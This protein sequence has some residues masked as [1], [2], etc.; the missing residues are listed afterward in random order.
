MKWFQRSIGFF[1]CLFMLSPLLGFLPK[2]LGEINA[3]TLTEITSDEESATIL[4]LEK[5]PIVIVYGH[6]FKVH[7]KGVPGNIND[8]IRLHRLGA[9]DSEFL[10]AKQ[11]QGQTS[12]T[13]EFNIPEEPGGYELRCWEKDSERLLAVSEPLIVE[14]G[15]A[16]IYTEF[17]VY[18]TIMR[19]HFKFY[20]SGAPGFADDFIALYRVDGEERH[21]VHQET[22]E[23]VRSNLLSMEIPSLP[24]EYELSLWA[25]DGLA[26]LTRSHRFQV[27]WPLSN[28]SV[29]LIPPDS[30]DKRKLLLE[31]CGIPPGQEGDIIGLYR[32][33]DEESDALAYKEFGHMLGG[34]AEWEFDVPPEPAYY[35]FRYMTAGGK[36]LVNKSPAIHS[37]TGEILEPPQNDQMPELGYPPLWLNAIAGNGKVYLKWTS[38]KPTLKVKSYRLYRRTNKEEEYSFL[39]ELDAT[40]E[41]YLDEGVTVYTVYFYQLRPVDAEGQEL[42]G[43]NEAFVLPRKSSLWDSALNFTRTRMKYYSFVGSASPGSQVTVNG[44]EIPVLPEGHFLATV[45]LE[46]G[47]NR[48]EVIATNNAGEKLIHPRL[49]TL[50]PI[51]PSWPKGMVDIVL[52]IGSK[53]ARVN[54]KTRELDVA[55]FIDQGRTM[56]PFR[57]VGESLSAKVSFTTDS[58][59][60][61]DIVSYTLGAT[62]V[63]LFIGKMEAL[64]NGKKYQLEAP[65]RIVQ[66]RT[67]VPVRFVSEALGC[68]VFWNA[69]TQEVKIR[70]Q[71]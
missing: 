22:L 30:E 66:G 27:I 5:N 56:V 17:F 29:A 59:G 8:I 23:H 49:I 53:Q 2:A 1:V 42:E 31:F 18:C 16:N 51:E 43:S 55:P 69:A 15:P 67:V 25:K 64:V 21:L 11:L 10:Y 57:F 46:L 48:V 40:E 12:G 14:W 9:P 44:I 62:H 63:I 35:E 6:Q 19:R 39:K 58:S 65:A 45:E 13:V 26:E 61:V 54:G 20:Y 41:N 47:T 28:L 33:G 37:V 3:S 70:Y 24:G 32:A 38:P 52:T 71:D 50:L 34:R 4:E 68:E 36:I 60:Q 7:F